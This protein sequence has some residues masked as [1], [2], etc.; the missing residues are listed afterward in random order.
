MSLD[1]FRIANESDA[2]AIAELVNAA[3]RPR[4]SAAGWTHESELLVGDRTNPTQVSEVITKPNSAILVGLKNSAIVA[5]VHIE[6]EGDNGHIGM[7]AVNPALQAAG[8]G[9]QM[10]ALAENYAI[11]VFG[12]EKFILVVVSLRSE[13]IAFYLR[14]GYQKTGCV[15]D[16]PLSA[17]AGIPKITALQIEVLEKR[18]NNAINSDSEKRRSFVAPL[19][20]AGYSER[21]C[22]AWHVTTQVKVLRP[23]IRRAEGEGNGKGVTVRWGLKEAEP[24]AAGR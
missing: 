12:A 2:S 8:V 22:R 11:E 14:R 9:K 3:Y 6:K 1:A 5:C 23:G 7:L 15:M 17:G 19:F 16:Y 18:S 13:L 21:V 10:L 4:P 24:K 20:T